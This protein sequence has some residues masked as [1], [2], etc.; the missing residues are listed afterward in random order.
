LIVSA[1]WNFRANDSD[2]GPPK[3]GKSLSIAVRML[4][5]TIIGSERIFQNHENGKN[6][7]NQLKAT[8]LPGGVEVKFR[9][10]IFKRFSQIDTSSV[11]S[12]DEVE[13]LI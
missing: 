8:D 10:L 3:Q 13:H 2:P 4:G 6:V 9:E 7:I 11:S 12:I 1:K 5:W